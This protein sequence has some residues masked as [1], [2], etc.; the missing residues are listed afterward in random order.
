M[1]KKIVIHMVGSD[2]GKPEKEKEFNEWYN[3]RHVPMMLKSPYVKR[4]ARYERIGD[5]K[6]F[7][8]YLAIYEMES[9]EALDMFLKSPYRQNELLQDSGAKAKA[10]DFVRRWLVDYKQIA[11]WEK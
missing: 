2:C 6:E 1:D 11:T 10:G 9:D 7:P 8:E 4:A 3:N 5:N